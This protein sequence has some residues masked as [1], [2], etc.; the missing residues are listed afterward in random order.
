MD[1]RVGWEV[2]ILVAAM[3]HP[4]HGLCEHKANLTDPKAQFVAV[5]ISL[6]PSVQARVICSAI[7][8]FQI[9]Q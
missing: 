9:L 7:N 2:N 4:I 6:H 3:D 5:I 1:N 8:L